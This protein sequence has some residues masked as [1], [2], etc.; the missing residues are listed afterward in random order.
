M[1]LQHNKFTCSHKQRQIP[2]IT[3][4]CSLQCSS[5]QNMPSGILSNYSLGTRINLCVVP[6]LDNISVLFRY[7]NKYSPLCSSGTRQVSVLFQYCNKYLP[8]C[9][10]DTEEEGLHWSGTTTIFFRQ[11]S[12]T[13]LWFGT[14]NE[15]WYLLSYTQ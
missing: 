5:L 3:T 2:I 6:V 9:S 15:A 8:L 4:K 10:S 14:D 7:Y 1:F 11:W 12:N 13:K